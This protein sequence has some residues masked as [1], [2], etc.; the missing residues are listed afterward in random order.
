MPAELR[1]AW[2]QAAVGHLRRDF[3]RAGVPLPAGIQV[4]VGFPSS[5]RRGVIG[6][7]WSKRAAADGQFNIFISPQIDAAVEVLGVLTHELVHA[8]DDC[9]SGH[10]GRFGRLARA[11]GL[12]G[13][14]T[15]TSTG[16]ELLARLNALARFLG[17]YPHG[18]INRLKLGTKAQTTR[19]IEVQCPH[20]GYIVRTTDKW[21][22]VGLPRCPQGQ[23]MIPGS[24]EMETAC[25]TT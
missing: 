3:V 16:P 25:L 12:V 6:E 4:S 2:L 22:S 11:V 9:R 20:C 15:S 17:P 7:C 23:E 8:A 1:E 21:L 19:L 13:P 5:R 24:K 18:A 10:R 14:L